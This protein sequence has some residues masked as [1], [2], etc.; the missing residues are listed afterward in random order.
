MKVDL[1]GHPASADYDDDDEEEDEEEQARNFDSP[2][3][4]PS[5]CL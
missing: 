2:E 5:M 3:D 1:N 4:D